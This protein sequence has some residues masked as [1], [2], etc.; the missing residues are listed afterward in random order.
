MLWMEVPASR[1]RTSARYSRTGTFSRRQVSKTDRIAAT[2]GAASSLSTWSS[3]FFRAQPAASSFPPGCCSAR[4]PDHRGIASA[5][6]TKTTCSSLPCRAR[7]M[8]VPICPPLPVP[9]GGLFG[10]VVRPFFS[11]AFSVISKGERSLHFQLGRNRMLLPIH[12]AVAY[13][14]P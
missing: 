3:S 13:T 8:A 4:S 5:S 11:H 7:S 10:H 12:R 2:F 1:G 6:A 14:L 9:C